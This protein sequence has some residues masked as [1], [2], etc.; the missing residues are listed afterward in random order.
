MGVVYNRIEKIPKNSLRL[1]K[2]GKLIMKTR[3][4]LIRH[5]VTEANLSNLFLGRTDVI[6]SEK[7][8][9][10]AKALSKRLSDEM[11]IDVIYSSNMKRTLQTAYYVASQ[12]GIP[13]FISDKLK[14]INF[15]NWEGKSHADVARDYPY[16]FLKWLREQRLLRSV[17]GESIKSFQKRLISE[18]KAIVKQNMGK[19]VCIVSH[20]ACIKALMCYFK[21]FTIDKISEVPWSDNTGISVIEFEGE[22]HLVLS[23]SD[24]EHLTLDL[25]PNTYSDM[26]NLIRFAEQSLLRRKME[27]VGG[28]IAY[29]AIVMN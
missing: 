8:L 19:T 5:A 12:Q 14:E 29:K 22:D 20:G 6:L 15:G 25:R 9:L 28:K 3:L 24:A 18:V 16:E 2:E 4:I 26:G 27:I 21:G 1:K 23:M 13:V 17:H 11:K 10:Q 7:G